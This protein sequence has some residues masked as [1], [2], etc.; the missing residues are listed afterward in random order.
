MVGG[1]IAA[2]REGD[3]IKI[4]TTNRRLDVDLPDAEIRA[5]LAEWKQPAPRYTT[6]VLA[7]YAALVTQASEGATT[8]PPAALLGV[9]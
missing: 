4:D 6:G 2:I 8:H 3:T 1:P 5:R 7:K 9:K